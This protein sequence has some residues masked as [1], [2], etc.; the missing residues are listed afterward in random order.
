MHEIFATSCIFMTW[1]WLFLLGQHAGLEIFSTNSLKQHSVSKHVAAFWH[2]ILIMSPKKTFTL[3]PKWCMI[4]REAAH[5]NF[6]V[7]GFS[8]PKIQPTICCTLG[9]HTNWYTAEEIPQDN[10]GKEINY[11]KFKI[12][13]FYLIGCTIF[14]K[15]VTLL[16]DIK[17]N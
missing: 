7:I 12:F 9:K 16:P 3:T 15:D 2:I 11:T 4:N 6:I 17:R 5:N 8:W 10:I 1:G 13:F 14:G